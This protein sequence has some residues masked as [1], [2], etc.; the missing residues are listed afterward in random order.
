MERAVRRRN[1]LLHYSNSRWD[2]A[3]FSWHLRF[4]YGNVFS[5]PLGWNNP[6]SRLPLY[7]QCG[8]MW[9]NSD[10]TSRKHSLE[11]ES[12]TVISFVAIK[13]S[14]WLRITEL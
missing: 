10:Q 2:S 5:F 13:K 9:H 14:Y 1:K 8:F 7:A 3:Y 6:L 12:G 4:P 11:S